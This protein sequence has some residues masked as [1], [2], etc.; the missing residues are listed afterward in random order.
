[1]KTIENS[2]IIYKDKPLWFHYIFGVLITLTLLGFTVP[3]VIPWV[4]G[5]SFNPILFLI[6]APCSYFFYLLSRREIEFLMAV[7]QKRPI[8]TINSEG[9]TYK[10]SRIYKWSE[11]KLITLRLNFDTKSLKICTTEN[12]DRYFL[13]SSYEI[14]EFKDFECLKKILN[15]YTENVEILDE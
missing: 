3:F 12:E 6:A 11:I 1:M 14:S 13:E 4:F 2:V 10:A 7:V 8:M 9:L 15:R 5:Y